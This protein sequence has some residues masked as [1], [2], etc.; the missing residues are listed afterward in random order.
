MAEKGV[1]GPALGNAAVEL[2]RRAVA[3]RCECA[4]QKSECFSGGMALVDAE[5]FPVRTMEGRVE[6]ALSH[7]RIDL[8]RILLKDGTRVAGVPHLFKHDG[9]KAGIESRGLKL[10][11]EDG[12]VLRQ[13][14]DR[15]VVHPGKEGAFPRRENPKALRE[16]LKRNGVL[17]QSDSALLEVEVEHFECHV[18]SSQY[19]VEGREKVFRAREKSHRLIENV[20]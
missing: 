18:K 11:L 10:L 7:Q 8:A 2:F 4:D 15:P 1:F 16:R 20:P 12:F 5:V 14:F 17:R 6:L 9:R 3:R 19:A 13:D